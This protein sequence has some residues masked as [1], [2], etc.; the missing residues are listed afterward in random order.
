MTIKLG[1][2]EAGMRCEKIGLQ[3]SAKGAF[4]NLKPSGFTLIELLVVI[5]IIAILAAL[6]LSALNRAKIA[7]DSTAC[8]SNL[9]QLTLA[10]AMYTQQTG[11]Y[12]YYYGWPIELQSFVGS[13]WPG[14]NALVE[15][16]GNT[17]SYSGSGVWACPVYNRLRGVFTKVGAGEEWAFSR[18]AYSYNTAGTGTLQGTGYGYDANAPSLGLGGERSSSVNG[19]VEPP[20]RENQVSTPSDMIALSDAPL[21]DQMFAGESY[22]ALGGL[23]YL[24]EAFQNASTYDEAILSL[25]PGDPAAKANQQRHGGRWNVGFCDGHVESLRM[26]GLFNLT[27]SLV[28]MRWNND[29]QSHVPQGWLPP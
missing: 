18:G 19:S 7:A 11:T 20:I 17:S 3:C 12:P 16:T 28:A 22:N 2:S 24:D 14:Q 4:R 10:M 29:H 21:D 6:L 23:L 26:S 15:F 25:P 1:G 27:N 13:P 8:R 9:R 5:A